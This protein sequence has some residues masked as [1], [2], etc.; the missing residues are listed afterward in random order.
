MPCDSCGHPRMAHKEMTLAV[1]FCNK[2]QQVESNI[3]F[4][5]DR[6]IEINSSTSSEDLLSDLY[7]NQKS[8]G[9]KS[10]AF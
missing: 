3:T 9:R 4:T 5:P 7:Y 10:I 8:F 2:C 6:K 1:Y